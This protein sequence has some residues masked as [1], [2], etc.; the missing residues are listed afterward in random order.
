M[1]DF[2]SLFATVMAGLAAYFAVSFIIYILL[3]IADW[4]IFTKAGEPGWMSLIPILNAY[5]TFKISWNT[6][7]FWIMMGTLAGGSICTGLAGED[8]GALA[9]IG[10][11]LSLIGVVI[12][13]IDIYKL[14]KSFGHGIGFTL[15]LI[16][17][18]PLFTLIL[19]FGSSKYI[20]PEGIPAANKTIIS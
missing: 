9:V 17:F 13:I 2:S 11:I 5:I 19:G 12:G 14:S 16:F 1:G 18:L 15:G 4:K 20:G 10:A 8:G 6:K 7:M 3:V